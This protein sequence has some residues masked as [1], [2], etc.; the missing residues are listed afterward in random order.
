[1]NGPANNLIRRLSRMGGSTFAVPAPGKRE[2]DSKKN[3]LLDRRKLAIS[4]C[5]LA[6]AVSHN[7]NIPIRMSIQRGNAK[8]GRTAPIS[9]R[10]PR[11]RQLQS[12]LLLKPDGTAA[13]L[14]ACVSAT[15]G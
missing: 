10:A 2:G 3:L 8:N 4:H 7:F 11:A 13:I 6:Y 1:M 14:F 9:R 15:A 5:I 12:S